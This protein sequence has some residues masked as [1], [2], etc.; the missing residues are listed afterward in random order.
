MDDLDSIFNEFARLFVGTIMD[1][2]DVAFP[3]IL[4]RRRLDGSVESLHEVDRY[5]DYLHQNRDRIQHEEWRITLLRAGAYLGEVIRHA[6]PDGEFRWVDYNDYMAEHPDLR[7]M[8]P[9]RTAATCACSRAAKTQISGRDAG[10]Q[11]KL[12]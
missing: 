8:I 4:G 2:K 12:K 3:T 11:R 10:A 1:E 5:L 6:A 9:D 7:K